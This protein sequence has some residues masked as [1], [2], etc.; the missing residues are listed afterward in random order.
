MA[1][2]VLISDDYS[3][4]RDLTE[5]LEKRGH[6]VIPTDCLESRFRLAMETRPDLFIVDFASMSR[7]ATA[8]WQH[9]LIRLEMQCSVLGVFGALDAARGLPAL[10]NTADTLAQKEVAPRGRPG[11]GEYGFMSLDVHRR[12][13]IIRGHSIALTP[14]ETH[15]LSILASHAGSY[16]SPQAIVAEMHGC[17]VGEREAG[18]IVRVHIHN[19]RRKFQR[20]GGPPYIVSVRGKGYLLER[21]TRDA[22]SA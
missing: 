5:Q 8:A 19:L 3:L 1:R 20:I 4:S 18:D 6:V 12:E 21:R 14:S 10:V 16:V 15:I 9:I 17:D 13:V 22:A 7:E 11:A 2:I